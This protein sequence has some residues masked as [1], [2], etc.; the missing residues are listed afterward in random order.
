MRCWDVRA[1]IGFVPALLFF[2]VALQAQGKTP[3]SV[4]PDSLTP[5]QIQAFQN[6]PPEQKKAIMDAIAKPSGTTSQIER[7]GPTE[8]GDKVRPGVNAIPRGCPR[9]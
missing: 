4:T 1:P 9:S 7:A 2:F 3:S 6:L 5:E 8:E